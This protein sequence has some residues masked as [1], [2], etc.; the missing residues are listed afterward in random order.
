MESER[1]DIDT[2]TTVFT[3]G[4]LHK[5][6]QLIGLA[7]RGVMYFFVGLWIALTKSIQTIVTLGIMLSVIQLDAVLNLSDGSLPVQLVITLIP[8]AYCICLGAGRRIER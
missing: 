5:M 3:G 4:V 6:I 7:G 1:N 8:V 2:N